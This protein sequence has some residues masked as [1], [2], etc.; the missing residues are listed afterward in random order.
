MSKN[1]V[2][3]LGRQWYTH[4]DLHD[5]ENNCCYAEGESEERIALF[6]HEGVG[7]A[8]LS[9]ILDIP[10]PIFSTH[11]D[12]THTCVSVIHFAHQDGI[13]I[14]K[15]LSFSNDSHLYREGLPS[16]HQNEI[17]Y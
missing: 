11:F 3:A 12:M 13:V 15:L 8:I 2:R 4:P 6:T 7:M 1:E 10:Y 9:C 16:K 17:Y 14:P 5:L